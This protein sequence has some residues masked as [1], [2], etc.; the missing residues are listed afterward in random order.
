MYRLWWHTSFDFLI[1]ILDFYYNFY[2]LAASV[3]FSHPSFAAVSE[4][5]LTLMTQ[6]EVTKD[7]GR[8]FEI[9]LQLVLT[10]FKLSLP[11]I[12]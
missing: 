6:T 12:G 10:C 4:V 2:K 3:T 1:A 8:Y 9:G 11:S 5:S 7:S